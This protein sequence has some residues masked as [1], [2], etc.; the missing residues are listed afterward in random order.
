M[1]LAAD[2]AITMGLSILDLFKIGVG[3]SSSH[4]VGPM[5]AAN[6]F[7]AELEQRQQLPQTAEVRIELYGS[8]AM[9][10]EG[11]A[12]DTAIILGLMGEQPEQLDPNQAP[13]LI[14]Q[15]RTTGELNLAKQHSVPFH[16]PR[17]LLFLHG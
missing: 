15:V 4:T 8:L 6:R 16:E 13:E 10:G 5:V 2:G 1:R 11:H 14:K 3:P 12:T 9:T 7:I 17:H